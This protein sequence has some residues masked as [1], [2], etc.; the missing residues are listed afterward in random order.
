MNCLVIKWWSNFNWNNVFKIN[1][2][3]VKENN[4]KII[5]LLMF[6]FLLEIEDLEKKWKKW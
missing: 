4:I 5:I 6:K 2:D 3:I 1:L